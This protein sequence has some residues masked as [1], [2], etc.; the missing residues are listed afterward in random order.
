MARRIPGEN[1]S[2]ST[3]GSGLGFVML[4]W[5]LVGNNGLLFQC[6]VSTIG[7]DLDHQRRAW[8]MHICMSIYRIPRCPSYDFDLEDFHFIPVIFIEI[9]IR[10]CDPSAPDPDNSITFV[11][12]RRLQTEQKKKER[13][14]AGEEDLEVNERIINCTQFKVLWLKG[15]KHCA[16]MTF[17]KRY[18]AIRKVTDWKASLM[19][20]TGVSDEDVFQLKHDGTQAVMRLVAIPCDSLEEL[21]ET[22]ET[23]IWKIKEIPSVRW[24]YNVRLNQL[25]AIDVRQNSFKVD[26]EITVFR[27]MLSSELRIWLADQQRFNDRN[28]KVHIGFT[29]KCKEIILLNKEVYADGKPF[30]V[31][32]LGFGQCFWIIT[33]YRLCAEYTEALELGSFP[34]DVQHMQFSLQFDTLS[35][36]YLT[37]YNE[38]GYDD[39]LQ[40]L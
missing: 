19:K 38:L 24:F 35:Q 8:L 1:G 7:F 26:A 12:K 22:E 16:L 28:L 30:Q 2:K 6:L 5:P 31:L 20:Q 11:S 14:L 25:S 13:K 33:R 10:F 15:G 23:A 29:P 34:F 17:D 39:Y 21:E 3:N 18:L 40:C 9:V 4:R 32:W 37:V 27:Q 36:L